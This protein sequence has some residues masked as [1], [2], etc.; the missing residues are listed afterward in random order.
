LLEDLFSLLYEMYMP[1]SVFEVKPLLE[2]L[3]RPNLWEEG[4]VLV[5]VIV[6]FTSIWAILAEMR[7]NHA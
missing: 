7:K 6:E 3:K 4:L 5:D 2:S 1:G